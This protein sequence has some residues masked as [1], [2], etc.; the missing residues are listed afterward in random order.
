MTRCNINIRFLL[1][2]CL[3]YLIQS[4][5]YQEDINY[6]YNHYEGGDDYYEQTPLVKPRT[7]HVPFVLSTAAC[8][9]LGSKIQSKKACKKL[10]EKHFAQQKQ[11]YTQYYNDVYK[12]QNQN[13]E[14]K[15]I[16]QQLKTTLSKTNEEIELDK[17]QRDYDEFKVPDLDGDDRINRAEFSYYIEKYLKN[18]PGLEEKDYPKFEDFDH[19][20]DGFI[21]FTEYGQ[22]MALLIAQADKDKK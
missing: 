10:S 21:S 3:P 5:Q 9:F 12:L 20:K 8:Y 19:D 4:Q 11:I 6:D 2:V 13:E 1:F 7:N 22:Q 15:E 17:V 16:I 14:L 18:Y